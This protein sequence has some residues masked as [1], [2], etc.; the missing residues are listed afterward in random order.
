MDIGQV[1]HVLLATHL[2][3]SITLFGYKGRKGLPTSTPSVLNRE[4]QAILNRTGASYSS[5]HHMFGGNSPNN[6]TG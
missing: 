6:V 4:R 2:T 5:L 3:S 1:K